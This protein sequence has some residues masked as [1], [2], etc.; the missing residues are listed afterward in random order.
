MLH[1]FTSGISS[2]RFSNRHAAEGT[3]PFPWIGVPLLIGV[4][5][6]CAIGLYA[7]LPPA[8]SADFAYSGFFQAFWHVG[9]FAISALLLASSIFGFAF[10]P[11][12]SALR[13]F[14]LGCNVAAAFQAQG[15]RGMLFSLFSFGI[16]ALLGLPAFLLACSDF[17]GFSLR[18]FRCFSRGEFRP[19]SLQGAVLRHVLI[20]LILSLTETLYLM[21]LLPLAFEAFS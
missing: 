8:L 11:A 16:P 5:S 14:L 2:P 4:V 3:F 12:L 7:A 10:I 9:C 17:A 19:P 18:L 15:L 20:V 6:G 13:G 1:S 21:F